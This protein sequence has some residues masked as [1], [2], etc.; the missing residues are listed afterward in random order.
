MTIT[1]KLAA[2]TVSLK[3][4]NLKSGVLEQRGSFFIDGGII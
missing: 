4:Q 2:Y 1:E 3:R